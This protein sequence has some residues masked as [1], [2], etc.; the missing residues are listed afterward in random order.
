MY[1]VHISKYLSLIFETPEDSSSWFGYYNYDT[2]NEN[3]SKMLSCRALHDAELPRKGYLVD[4]GYYDIPSGTWHKVGSS[5]S[6]N[7]P[8]GCM[9]QWLP[10]THGTSIIYNTSCNN[11]LISRIFDIDNGKSRDIDWPIYGITP[12]GKKSISIDLERSYFSLAYHYESVVNEEKNVRVLP[13]DGIFEIDL[14]TNT[15]KCIIPIESI[16]EADYDPMFAECKHWLEH[17]MISPSGT[18]F[19]FLHRFCPLNDI[20][21]RQTRL[22]IADIDGNNLQIINGWK[23]FNWSHFGWDGDKAFS[24]YTYVKC[25]SFPPLSHVGEWAKLFFRKAIGLYTRLYAPSKRK[26]IRD[27]ILGQDSYYQYYTLNSNGMFEHSENLKC[28]EFSIDGHQSYTKDGCFMIADTYPDDENY[29]KLLLYSKEKKKVLE[30]G[31]LYAGLNKKPGS[32]DLHPKLCRNNN[33]LVV[34]SAYNGQHHMLLFRI[35][36]DLINKYFKGV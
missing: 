20:H 30:L 10:N 18:K 3:Q 16:I 14:E 21:K 5:D 15:R 26:T 8:Q 13:G 31:K 2:L 36:W 23:K 1:N 34:D 22:C 11:R 4:V 6:Y 27:S 35:N 17:V 28:K 25:N 29:Q 9:V 7:W 19:C 32:C 24:I 12:D 33:L